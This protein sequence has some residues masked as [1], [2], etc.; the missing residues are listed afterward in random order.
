MSTPEH[1]PEFQLKTLSVAAVPAALDRAER[2]RLLNEP[3]QAESICLDVIAAQPD[4]Q[5]ATAL[6]LLA[7]ADQF[8][9]SIRGNLDRAMELLPRFQ[10][11]YQREYYKGILCERQARVYM[12]RSRDSAYSTFREA[13]DCYE[14]AEKLKP[15]GNDEALL[16]WNTCARTIMTAQLEPP[17]RDDS[18]AMLE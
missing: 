15:A 12:S 4:N 13:M 10:D 16:R 5:R 3:A 9:E 17:T 6:L 7:L 14:R 2:Y 1:Q 11:E 8:A 18:I